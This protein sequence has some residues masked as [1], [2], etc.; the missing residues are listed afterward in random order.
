MNNMSILS[1]LREGQ[2]SISKGDIENKILYHIWKS[3][4]ENMQDEDFKEELLKTIKEDNEDEKY[5][6]MVVDLRDFKFVI[7]P[8]IQEWSDKN[9]FPLFR[10]VGLNRV[11]FVV[12][13]D[14]FS[15]ISVEQMLEEENAQKIFAKQYFDDMLKAENW[16]LN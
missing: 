6:S 15:Q 9:I 3:T 5:S 12:S 7:T 14:L 13:S 11:A 10:E 1:T 16:L 4:S 2:F 8:E